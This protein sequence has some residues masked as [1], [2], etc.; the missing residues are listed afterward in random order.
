MDS[1]QTMRGPIGF[2]ELGRCLVHEHIISGDIEHQLNYCPDF[3][4]DA[5]VKFA[6]KKLNAVKA[7]GMDSLIDLT[8]LGIGRYV[9][10]IVKV[11]KLTEL[12]IIVAA[13]CFATDNLPSPFALAPDPIEHMAELFA[14]D[15]LEGVQGTKVKAGVLKCA[16]DRPGLTKGVEQSIRAVARAHLRTGAPITVHTDA[17]TRTG[18]DAQRVLANEGVDLRDVI[19]GHCGDSKDL[20]YLTELADRGSI[21]GM[22]RFGM[23]H[24]SDMDQQVALVSEM[25]KRGYLRSLALSHDCFCWTNAFMGRRSPYPQHDYLTVPNTVMPALLLAGHTR[26]EIDILTIENPR[27]HFEAAAQRFAAQRQPAFA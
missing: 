2:D 3:D 12:N 5:E 24:R 13:G 25:I 17:D 22:D 20:G 11:A 27:R 21:L 9:P 16:I 8:V 19:I 6:A 18:L 26:E 7:A 1:I 15:I 14:R 10:R 23:S 4:E